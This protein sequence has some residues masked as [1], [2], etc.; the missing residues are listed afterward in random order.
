MTYGVNRKPMNGPACL[1]WG[2]FEGFY[3]QVGGALFDRLKCL[4]CGTYHQT[5]AINKAVV[6]CIDYPRSSS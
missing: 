6:F 4:C 3:Q 5:N 1:V 2:L